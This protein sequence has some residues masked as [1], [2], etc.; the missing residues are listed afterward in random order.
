MMKYFQWDESKIFNFTIAY[1]LSLLLLFWL[2]NICLK[3]IL[4]FTDVDPVLS[5]PDLHMKYTV[6][7]YLLHSY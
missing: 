3:L 1:F 7:V 4:V 5:V 2:F 6:E